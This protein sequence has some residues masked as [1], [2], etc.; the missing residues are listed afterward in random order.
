MSPGALL[1]FFLWHQ[2]Q[3]GNAEENLLTPTKNKHFLQ[4]GGAPWPVGRTRIQIR[5]CREQV[6]AASPT[7]TRKA[8]ARRADVRRERTVG[9]GR[10]GEPDPAF[11]PCAQPR[12]GVKSN[13]VGKRAAAFAEKPTL[14][15]VQACRESAARASEPAHIRDGGSVSQRTIGA[16]ARVKPHSRTPAVRNLRA[17]FR[18][19]KCSRCAGPFHV[20]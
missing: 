8:C 7:R 16:G 17:A 14:P 9:R 5:G 4:S 13:A 15:R 19:R 11:Q 18:A 10:R 2:P 6:P 3:H 12:R 1:S 20:A